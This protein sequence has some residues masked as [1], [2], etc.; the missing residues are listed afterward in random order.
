MLNAAQA[1]RQAGTKLKIVY[2]S[3]HRGAATSQQHSNIASGCGVVV[4]QNCPFKWDTWAEIPDE[5]KK[6]LREKLSVSI[7]IFSIYHFFNCVY[8][9]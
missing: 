9:Y 4:E 6:M 2:D 3:R 7:L 1:A 5:T 8:K